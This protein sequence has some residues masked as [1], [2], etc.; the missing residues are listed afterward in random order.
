MGSS[1]RRGLVSNGA[2][3]GDARPPGEAAGRLVGLDAA[4]PGRHLGIVE[5]PEA[6][7]FVVG[8]VPGD[9]GV[10]G[11]RER[12]KAVLLG[13]CCGG[14]Q[15]RASEALPSVGGMYR[16]LLDVAVAVDDVSRG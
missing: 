12:G 2:S 14:V 16:D 4:K 15:Q 10:G 9:V 11:E 5:R 7:A 13:P 8:G 6:Q 1:A 3:H